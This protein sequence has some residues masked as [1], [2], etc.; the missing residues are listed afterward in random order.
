[1]S[2]QNNVF[3]DEE[4]ELMEEMESFIAEV[5]KHPEITSMSLSENLHRELWRDIREYNEEK[6]KAASVVPEA[7]PK[8]PEPEVPRLSEEEKELIQLGKIY[9]RKKKNKKFYLLIAAVIGAMTL[10]ITSMGG[11]EKVFERFN[12]MLAGR[13]QTNIDS[14]GEDIKKMD[15][16]AEEEAYQQIED[17]YGV[18][19][20]QLGYLPNGVEY[21]KSD[22]SED[23]QFL[24]LKYG[25]DDE[26]NVSYSIR[27][28]YREASWGIDVEDGL[29]DEYIK[30]VNNV[31]ILIKEFH[32]EGTKSYRWT[33]E[34]SY[35]DLQYYLEIN[36]LT[37]SEFEEIIKNLKFL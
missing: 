8:E 36:Y 24:Q 33:A 2:S 27:P 12:W 16:V 15:G 29:Q 26:I 5:K 32:I 14:E 10:G 11:P 22:S 35:Q 31:E 19:P 20:V 23:M 28:N 7:V 30:K 13:E 25:R 4:L 17:E 21:A 3:T 1:M 37:E 18:W 6:T 34:Y 9:K